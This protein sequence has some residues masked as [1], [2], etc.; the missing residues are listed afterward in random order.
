MFENF[1]IPRY[2]EVKSLA[3]KATDKLPGLRYVGWDIAITEDK[4]IL[5]EG[6]GMPGIQISE[7]LSEIGFKK[8]LRKLART[9]IIPD[10][11]RTN[12]N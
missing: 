7:G 6:N 3:I 1:Q 5:V 2:E 12:Q 4:V 8:G 9:G 11:F 10:C